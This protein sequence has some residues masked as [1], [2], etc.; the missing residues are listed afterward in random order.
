MAHSPTDRER[1]EPCGVISIT[2]DFGHK[3]PFIGTMKGMILMRF[4]AARIV[5]LTHETLV[6]WP[7]EAGFWIARAYRYFPAGTLHVDRKS[8]RLNSSHIAVSRMPSSA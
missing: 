4:P 3:G 6:H 7:A 8:T 1:F 2:T 5:D